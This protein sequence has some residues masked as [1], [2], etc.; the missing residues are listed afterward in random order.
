MTTTL[1]TGGAGFIGSTLCR[2]LLEDGHDVICLDNISSGREQNIAEFRSKRNFE[3]VRGDVRNRPNEI[4]HNVDYDADEIDY[5]Y[6]MASRASPDDFKRYPLDIAETNADGTQNMLELA[7]M[8]DTPILFASTSEI[9][10]NPQEHPQPETYN[11]NVDPRG[12]RACYD[13][14]KRFGEMLT[15]VYSDQF[16]VDTRTARLFNTYGPRMRPDDGRVIPNFVRQAL[17]NES[18]TVYGDGS[19]TRSFL[20]VDDQVRGLRSLME[21]DS[22]SGEVVNIGST[23][24]VTIQTLA[25]TVV[26]VLETESEIT[27]EPLPYKNEPE[28]RQPN[29]SRAKEWLNW[30][31]TIELREGIKRTADYFRDNESL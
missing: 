1:V 17:N 2:S 12:A 31:P 27:Y 18:I 9:Y 29:I 4:L 24:E 11:G 25:E 19:Q 20:Y 30:E 5:I 23:D 16:D 7:R 21:T 6:H 13:E 15:S 26:E 14:S 8:S 22:L 10:G 28:R 3:F